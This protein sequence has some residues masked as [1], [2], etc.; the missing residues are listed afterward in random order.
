MKETFASAFGH[1]K[2]VPG[3]L[4]VRGSIDTERNR[5]NERGVDSHAGFERARSSACRR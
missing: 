4:K 2:H 1:G 5:V 3:A